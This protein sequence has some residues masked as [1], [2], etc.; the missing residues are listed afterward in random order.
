MSLPTG[1]IAALRRCSRSLPD[2]RTGKNTSYSTGGL[3]F[4]AFV[5]FFMQSPSFLARQRHLETAQGRS[6]CQTLFGMDQIPCDVRV[7]TMLDPVESSHFYP[8]FADV[9]AEPL[10]PQARKGKVEYFQTM[11][12]AT[13][14][15]PGHNRAVPLEPEFVVPHDGHEKQDCGSR[16]ARRWLSAHVAQYRPLNPVYL[17][18]YLFSR[19]PI[20]EVVL[21]AGDIFCSSASRIRI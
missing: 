11:L 19:Q 17:S 7:G 5:P 10:A 15:A 8:L 20:C 12:A 21:A 9:I 18:N 6:N 13:I 1:L 14:V 4:A 3:A 16:A 2:P